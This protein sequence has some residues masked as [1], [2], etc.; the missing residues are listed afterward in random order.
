MSNAY[1]IEDRSLT[2]LQAAERFAREWLPGEN[3]QVEWLDGDKFRLVD[4]LRTYRV[5]AVTR[6]WEIRVEVQP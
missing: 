3:R 5:V 4:G 2:G 1:L 6:G